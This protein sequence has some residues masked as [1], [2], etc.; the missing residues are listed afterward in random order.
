MG[1]HRFLQLLSLVAFIEV[2]GGRS[3]GAQVS[4][5][6]VEETN[7]EA[8]ADEVPAEEALAEEALAEEVL[9]GEVVLLAGEAPYAGEPTTYG[10]SAPEAARLPGS[11]NDPLRA[12][13]NM[14]GVARVPFGIGGLVLRG[15]SPRDSNIYLDDMEIPLAF[16][17]GGLSS[18]YPATMLSSLDVVPGSFGAAYGR[19]QGGI[20]RMRSRPGRGDRWRMGA[21][22][23][24]IDAAVRA[25]G[26]AAGGVFTLGFRRS[27]IDAVLAAAL[28]EDTD[29]D[30]T[31]APR[32][33][34]V[35]VRYDRALGD[36]ERIAVT[37]I[38]SDDRLRFLRQE[39]LIGYQ[40][41]F[42]RLGVRWHRRIGGLLLRVSPWLGLDRVSLEQG[43][44]R[45][46]RSGVPM[47]GRAS[48]HRDIGLRGH[49]S[50]GIDLQ[51]GR[52]GYQLTGAPAG[53]DPEAPT[54]R[55]GHLWHGDLALY[56][57]GFYKIENGRLGLRPGLR[58]ERYGLSGDVVVDPRLVVSHDLPGGIRLRESIGLYHQPPLA[59]DVD[60]ALGDLGLSPSYSVQ[61]TV[62]LDLQLGRSVEF[63]ATG[64]QDQLYDQPVALTSPDE[65]ASAG[66]GPQSGGFISI[67]R[68]LA[69]EQLGRSGAQAN[70]G[71]GDNRG[72]ELLLKARGA[73]FQG[74]LAYTFTRTR[75]SD[76]PTRLPLPRPYILDQPHAFTALA[77][78]RLGRA[79][80]LGARLRYVS[81]N[82]YT[83]VAGT[84]R[85]PETGEVTPIDGPL[86]SARLPAFVQL[87]LRVDRTFRGSFGVIAV[88]LDLQN[89]SNRRNAEGP[90]YNDDYSDMGYTRGLPIIPSVGVKYTY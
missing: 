15:S 89:A 26:P 50:V 42:A 34:D 76:D 49:V 21:E 40:A 13:Q 39:S 57:E 22:V 67:G 14:P 6:G 87:D 69:E 1:V 65:P 38:G 44:E 48:V 81:G 30:L 86:L 7:E 4:V 8:P 51:G 83:P 63:S 29:I 17:F 9:A 31:L 5:Q 66:T 82:P 18:V 64:F 78:V 60:P 80:Q 10:L 52:S 72:L 33:Y 79:W 58:I 47:G 88:F 32:Y 55:M 24:V 84:E 45:V 41:S 77:S 12:L 11:G 16:H 25:E 70:M 46:V 85:D 68:E 62:G 75:R 23:S 56:A 20:V 54:E 73:G 27:Y 28:P 71:R 61:A 37:F 35:Q 74:W 53:G 43:D 59:V 2:A 90:S 19:A 36:N 3:A